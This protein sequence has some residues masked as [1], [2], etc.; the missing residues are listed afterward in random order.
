MRLLSLGIRLGQ[1]RTWFAEAKIQ[2]A[3]ESLA[4]AHAHLQVVRFFNPGRQSLAV[5]EIHSHS[6]IAGV[7]PEH[8]IDLLDLL[9]VQPTRAACPFP[10]LQAG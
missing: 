6:R 9:F 7:G 2:L 4:L 10:L 8:A 1:E 5:P 3:E